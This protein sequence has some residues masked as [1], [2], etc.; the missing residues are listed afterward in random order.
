[1]DEYSKLVG[2]YSP[3]AFTGK[4]LSTGGSA[5][6]GEATA[7]GWLFVLKAY[8]E[9]QNEKLEGKKIILQW[10]GNVWL[11]MVKLLQDTGVILLWISDSKTAIYDENG[12][13]IE[14]ILKFK[15]EKKSF[16][17][18][19]FWKKITNEELL[20]KACDVLIPA[21]L[22]N[23][24]TD[25]NA[26]DI[27][28]KIIL[29]LANGPTTPEADVILFDKGIPV[30]PDILANAGGVTV[31]YFEQIQNNTNYYWDA[32]EVLEKLEKKMHKAAKTVFD[33]AKKNDT[34]IRQWAYIIAIG[35]IIDAMKARGDL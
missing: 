10:A 34:S 16:D 27:C 2:I 11:T 14:T 15:N 31:S 32:E 12:L 35:R 26:S 7:Q 1:M 17:E 23:Q 24:I 3:G 18:A 33:A 6:R 21:A 19:N 13:D 20:V 22:E 4:P 8:L 9:A 30:I 28:A 29:E 5:G 25:K